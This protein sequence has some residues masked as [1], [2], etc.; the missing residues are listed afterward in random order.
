MAQTS[1]SEKNARRIATA[2]KEAL[3]VTS[4]AG[5]VI[6][7]LIIVSVLLAAESARRETYPKTV[8]AVAIAIVL[9]WLA[10]SYSDLVTW[11]VREGRRL[12][13]RT[14]ARTMVHDLPLVGGAAVP[15]ITV[16]ISWAA[17]ADLQSALVIALWIDVATIVAVEV[18]AGIRAELSGRELLGQVLVGAA[19]GVLI[20]LLRL[21]LH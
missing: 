10:H 8:E 3:S 16:L 21:V 11:R 17:G 7:G 12:T 15:L 9:Y 1:D 4:N 5:A 13:A 14:L 6:Y 20:L 2:A 18:A 19:L